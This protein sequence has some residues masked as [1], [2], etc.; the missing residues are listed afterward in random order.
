[1]APKEPHV[2]E[3]KAIWLFKVCKIANQDLVST[4]YIQNATPTC[5][6]EFFSIWSQLLG[7]LILPLDLNLTNPLLHS[8]FKSS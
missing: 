1:M 7:L 8:N 3:C 2:E 6:D 4:S 5:K